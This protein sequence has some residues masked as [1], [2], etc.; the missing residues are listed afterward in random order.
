MIGGERDRA[1]VSPSRAR[2]N[3]APAAIAGPESRP[4]RLQQDIGFDADGGEMLGHQETI[5]AV[6]DDD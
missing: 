4:H 1:A 5:V 6:G 2:A 3:A